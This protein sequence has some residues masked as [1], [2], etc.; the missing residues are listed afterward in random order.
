M[1]RLIK[2]VFIALLSFSESLA[3]KSVS[4]NNEPCKI[5]STLIDLNPI[6][7]NHY[8]FM[9]SLDK[10]NG[11]CNA[12]DDLSTKICVSNK[13]KNV[14]TRKNVKST[15]KKDHSWNLSACTLV[16]SRYLKS[17][18]DN[19]VTVWNETIN[20]TDS[21]SINVTN[22][23][24]TEVTNKMNCCILYTFLLAIILL[25][26]IGIIYYHFAKHRLI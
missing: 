5:R 2:Q 16:N 8:P 20:V 9:V 13:T 14:S 19:S 23:I 18:I 17:V 7:L 10:Y 1:F 12:V 3:T 11:I 6:E 25:F 24:S 22:I 15:R 21:V 26:I 4:L